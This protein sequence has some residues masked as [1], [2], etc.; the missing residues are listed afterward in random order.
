MPQT[1]KYK[2]LR[3]EL[4]G[5]ALTG[6]LV[7]ATTVV[8]SA[9]IWQI[10]LT[11]GT[12]AYLIPVLIAATHWGIVS[13]LF[14][15]VLGVLASAFFFFPPLYTLHVADP[16][17]V[18]NLVLYVCVAVV[19][20]QLAARLRRQVE[21][22]QRREIEMRDLYAF[23]RRLA[24]AFDVTDIQSAIE[25]HLTNVMHRK[26][27]LFAAARESGNGNKRRNAGAAPPQV[28]AAV[29]NFA[30]AGRD[31][32]TGVTVAGDAGE[33]WLVRA[34]SPKSPEFGLIAIN[35]GRH[36]QEDSDELRSRVDAALADATATLERLG[37]AYAINE[38]HM[39]S[40]TDQLREALIGSVSHELRT[41]LASILGAATVLSTAPALQSEPKLQAL[42]QDV[43]SE[44]ERLND[45]IQN[46]LDAT[47]ISSDGIKP[48]AEWADPADIIDSALERCRGRM[49]GHHVIL[50]MPSDL[51]LIHVDPVLVKQALVQIFDN[52]A[53][54]SPP[55]SRITVAARARDGRMVLS[56]SDQGAGLSATEQP[57]IWD[58]FVRGERQ[59]AT[60]SGSGLGLWIANAFIAANGGK[61]N[62]VSDGPG[63][64]ATLA[65]ELPVTQAAVPQ[66]ESDADE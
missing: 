26:V 58:R 8:I 16:Q 52:A 54:Y 33:V 45:D 34:V 7:A 38:A 40:Q 36:S 43:R 65:I 48:Q 57:Q 56:V 19:V 35:F 37:I 42:V 1:L 25:D 23:S 13:A 6:L 62:A 21:T 24:V 12:V 30:A 28:L 5:L 14:A 4:R 63:K 10:G 59:A 55:G 49:A 50:N 39:R 51:P 31:N 20:S 9:I 53:K 15:A 44:A 60:T 22:S 2:H 32:V 29:E 64:G 11:R 41:P 46:L 17:E 27:V 66:M 61:M 47:R 18:I 3:K